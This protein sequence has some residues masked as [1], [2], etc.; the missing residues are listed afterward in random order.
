[1]A[2]PPLDC[3]SPSRVRFSAAMRPAVGLLLGLLVPSIASAAPKDDARRH[4][5]AG[6]EAAQAKD[7]DTALEEFLIAQELYPRPAGYYNIARAYADLGNVP[8]AIENYRLFQ[9]A[10]PDKA[11]EVAPLI[12]VLEAR[13]RDAAPVEPAAGTGA[14]A[15]SQELD[16]LRQI[17]SELQ[18]ISETIATRTEPA[19]PAEPVEGDPSVAPV[20]LPANTDGFNSDAYDEVVVSASRYGQ[21][22]LDSPSTIT[23]VTDEDIR[24]SGATNIPD[25]LRRVV[26]VDVMQLTAAQ[27]DVSIRG[28]A[29]P[30]SNKVLVLIDGR[31]VYQDIMATPFWGVLPISLQEVERI[32]VI[33]GPG[34]ALYGANAVTG[35]INIITR[36]PGEGGNLLHVDAGDPGYVQG[37]ALVSGQDGPTAYRLSAGY[38]QTG[39]W[40]TDT[41]DHPE[42][43]L[44]YKADNPNLSL[45]AVRANGRVDR[46]LSDDAFLSLAGGYSRGMTEFH[47]FGRL[48]AYSLPYEYGLARA[49]L[50]IGPVH[51]RGFYNTLVADAGPW[52]SMVGERSLNTSVDSDTA[53]LEVEGDKTF[54]T[55]P[56][57]HR[58]VAGMGYRY[59]AI[60]WGYLEG[61]GSPI[62]EHHAR[63][64][65]QDQA[66][67]GRL[68][69]VGSFRVDR[70]PLVPIGK[71]LSPRAAVIYRLADKTSVRLNTGTS[72]RAP[73]QMESYLDLNQQVEADALFVR[74]HGSRNLDP[75]RI[76]TVETGIHDESSDFHRVDLAL[77]YNRVTDLIFVQDI[78]ASTNAYDPSVNGFAIGTTTFGNLEPVYDGFG[79]E[80]DT[81]FFPADGLDLYMNTAVQRTYETVASVS[82]VEGSAATVKVN[83]GAMVR[84]PWRVDLATHVHFTSSQTWTLRDYNIE[85]KLVGADVPIDSRTILVGRLGVRPFADDSLELAVTTWNP[86]A[87]IGDQ[88]TLEHAEGQYVGSRLFGSA[89]WR[90]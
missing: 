69:M 52:A 45:Q 34:S 22:P 74:T 76:F 30:L 28:F 78:V 49:D 65:V 6:Y 88:G 42:S 64:F 75:E 80:L 84:T 13:L 1:M 14:S 70:H 53:D 8:A 23:I 62:S 77:Y 16:R 81:R 46:Q 89:T 73:S 83:L 3:S 44:V 26:G 33:R 90:F 60:E 86:L 20:E 85:G 58:L 63:L 27:P 57:E 39:R 61:G 12:A 9:S 82:S 19:A 47:V 4:F 43:S 66:T 36:K 54:E 18:A 32:E 25:V 15:T 17:A 87:E 68:S 21:D 38:Q 7:F 48:A 5:V 10:A 37:T 41:I 29:R 31:G 51:I 11:D 67:A 24:M 55:G 35:V 71:T 2:S 72:F 59:K 56:L 40:S 79:A 50:N